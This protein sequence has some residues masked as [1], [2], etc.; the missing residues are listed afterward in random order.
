MIGSYY[1]TISNSPPSLPKSNLSPYTAVSSPYLI[2]WYQ[3]VTVGGISGGIL[4]SVQ[5]DVRRGPFSDCAG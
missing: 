1:R 4:C 5:G 2:S 3:L